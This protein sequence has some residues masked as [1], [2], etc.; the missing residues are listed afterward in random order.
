M[1]E[2][3]SSRAFNWEMLII[4]LCGLLEC[5]V[6]VQWLPQA[7]FNNIEE[8]NLSIFNLYVH[9]TNVKAELYKIKISDTCISN[10]WK[11]WIIQNKK[12]KEVQIN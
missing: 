6:W 12:I 2:N 11:T 3:V 9:K 10:E 4:I 7:L 1:F 8:S 5:E